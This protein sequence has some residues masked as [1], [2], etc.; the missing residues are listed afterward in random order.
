MS[1]VLDRYA[2]MPEWAPW[3]AA[4]IARFVNEHGAHGEL[5]ALIYF[6]HLVDN[7]RLHPK[8]TKP[9]AAVP[10]SPASP[11][12]PQKKIPF[13]KAYVTYGGLLKCFDAVGGEF[14]KGL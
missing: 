8:A 9:K 6:S 12:A 7:G 4:N 10:A 5:Q 3:R 14:T 13:K 11:K 2:A 1:S